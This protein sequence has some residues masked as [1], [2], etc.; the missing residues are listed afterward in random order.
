MIDLFILPPHKNLIRN[1][2]AG[3]AALLNLPINAAL[4]KVSTFENAALVR[5]PRNERLSV[6]FQAAHTYIREFSAKKL[7]V[8][9]DAPFQCLV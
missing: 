6:K 1:V 4:Q 7:E 9:R 5:E 2:R 3:G 8:K